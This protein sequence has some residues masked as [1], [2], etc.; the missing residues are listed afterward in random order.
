MH[1]NSKGQGK[2]QADGKFPDTGASK[3]NG[4]FSLISDEKLIGLYTNLVKCRAMEQ[5]NGASN[6]MNRFIRNHEAALVG[7]AID[8]GPGDLV[9]SLEHGLLASL[10]EG[11][12]IERLIV[13]S[14]KNGRPLARGKSPASNNGGPG[15]SFLHT[16]LGTA[17]AYKTAANGKI[18]VVYGAAGDPDPLAQ[19][20][21]IASVHALPIIFVQQ[22]SPD[23][24]RTPPNAHKT[25]KAKGTPVQ[26]PWFPAIAVDAHDV[27]AVYRVANESISRA[28]LGRGPTLIEY[29]PFALPAEKRNGRHSDPV[30]N[31]EHYLRAKGL[32]DPKLKGESAPDL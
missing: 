9:C 12:A 27:V 26:T 25:G 7:T 31:M 23:A 5:S 18:A 29:R 21:H 11:N 6:G 22:S 2:P 17:L 10:S 8:L 30:L 1:T 20:I 16:A 24:R 13:D 32:F 14:G 3:S 15:S 4:K 28:R 19:A